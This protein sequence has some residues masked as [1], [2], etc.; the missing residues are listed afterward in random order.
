M[1]DED[2]DPLSTEIT[3]EGQFVNSIG[4]LYKRSTSRQF[5]QSHNK[6]DENVTYVVLI[7][8]EAA[9]FSIFKSCTYLLLPRNWPVYYE[10]AKREQVIY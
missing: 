10:Q 6:S 5:T 8:P 7:K 1:T 9:K 3:L 2:D 4:G